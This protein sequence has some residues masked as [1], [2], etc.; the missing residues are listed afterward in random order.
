MKTTKI[1]NNGGWVLHHVANAD[2]REA[3]SMNEY[4]GDFLILSPR[5]RYA[6]FTDER[7][8]GDIVVEVYLP[9]E[10]EGLPPQVEF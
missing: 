6:T 4:W 3:G 7:A 8:N 2:K 1:I 5:G 9:W 10:G